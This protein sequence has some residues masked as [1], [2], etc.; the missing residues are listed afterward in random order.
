[1]P[2]YGGGEGGGQRNMNKCYEESD[3]RRFL[4]DWLRWNAAGGVLDAACGGCRF[5]G[6]WTCRKFSCAVVPFPPPLS[7]IQRRR[8]GGRFSIQQSARHP[9]P[10]DLEL[11]AAEAVLS[12]WLADCSKISPAF[13]GD[14]DDDDDDVDLLPGLT[15][16]KLSPVP[17]FSPVPKQHWRY[18]HKADDYPVFRRPN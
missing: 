4:T 2:R 6:T 1:M 16:S 12:N 14:D 11:L 10:F 7:N 13:I 9:F 5:L 8:R 18:P 17:K 3:Q 15:G